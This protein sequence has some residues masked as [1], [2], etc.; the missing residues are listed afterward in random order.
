MIS[1][2]VSSLYTNVPVCEAIDICADLL[3]KKTLISVDKDTFKILAKIASCNVIMSTHDGFYK[4]IDGLAMGSAPAPFLANGWLSQFDSQ[5]K[6]NAKIYFR[7]MDDIVREIP[8]NLIEQKLEEI[9][10]YHPS[11]KF[12]LETET[13]NSLPFLDMK[14]IR[15]EGQLSSIWYTKPTDTGLVMNY[16]AFAPLKYKRS[17]ISGFVYRIHRSC[18]SWKNFHISLEKAKLILTQNQYPASF[19][20]PIIHDTLEN[21]VLNKQKDELSKEEI[22][23]HKLFLVYR[24]KASKHFA[25]DLKRINTP[26]CTIFT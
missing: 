19:I 6:G 3:F 11:L 14:I 17:V 25:K 12:T 9:N 8:E 7:Y 20:E 18:S 16:H 26:D 15:R 10:N 23:K 1:F 22:E 5:I 4:Q 21:I 24:G 2:D 13:E